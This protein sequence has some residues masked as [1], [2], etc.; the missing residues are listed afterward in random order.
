MHVAYC[1]Q[2]GLRW[3]L[4]LFPPSVQK[5]FAKNCYCKTIPEIFGILHKKGKKSEDSR[6]K[7]KNSPSFS[8]QKLAF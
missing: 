8:D 4:A 7:E 6:E 5:E 3:S 1:S 2:P